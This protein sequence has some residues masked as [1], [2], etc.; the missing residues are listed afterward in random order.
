MNQ[1]N[2]AVVTLWRKLFI[3]LLGG[4]EFF[5]LT[6][7]LSCKCKT[8]RLIVFTNAPLPV[9]SVCHLVHSVCVCCWFVGF[10]LCHLCAACFV[11]LCVRS[12]WWSLRISLP[13]QI[14]QMSST[15]Q[16]QIPHIRNSTF[17]FVGCYSKTHELWY[18]FAWFW[19]SSLFTKI[20][21]FH[22]S[23]GQV[24]C[25]SRTE[26]HG[27]FS[28]RRTNVWLLSIFAW[29]IRQQMWDNV[30]QEGLNFKNT[31]IFQFISCETVIT[32]Q[33]WAVEQ[34]SQQTQV[35][36]N[37]YTDATMKTVTTMW[38]MSAAPLSAARPKKGSCSP[39]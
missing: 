2:L 9:K 29:W 31:T 21:I 36:F 6:C 15:L 27:S 22:K 7:Q 25:L 23:F 28:A 19:T 13:A 10:I 26:R 14:E 37:T 16:S 18:R 35:R 34:D 24:F 3:V 30:G 39:V 4:Q 38:L 32:T 20:T 1:S 5:Q 8:I 17:L 33:Y 12:R 11:V